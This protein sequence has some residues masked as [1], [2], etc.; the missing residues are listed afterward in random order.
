MQGQGFIQSAIITFCLVILFSAAD[1][2]FS[3]SIVADHNAVG[4]FDDIPSTVIQDITSQYNI[5]YAHTSHGSQIMTG[6]SI[7]YTENGLYDSP[8]FY[9]WGDDLGALGDT[10]W[11][12]HVRYYL[13]GHPDCNM[14][15]LSWCGGCSDNTEE[16]INAYLNKMEELEAAYPTVI[17]IYMT[18]HLDGTGVDGTLYANNNHIRDYCT[19][20]DKIL[21]DFADIESYDP[22]G[23]YYPDETDVCYWCADWCAVHTC[24]DCASCAH[25]HC[26]NC[27]LKGKGWW[28]MMARISGWNS[29]SDTI[30]HPENINPAPNTVNAPNNISGLDLSFTMLMNQITI[31][32]SNIMVHGSFG[33]LIDELIQFDYPSSHLTVTGGNNFRPNEII[34]AILTDDVLSETGIPL[35][36]NYVWEFMT[37]AD[38]GT[39]SFV[40]D[41]IQNAWEP[42]DICAGDFDGDG[43]IDIAATGFYLS[44]DLTFL[45]NNGDGTFTPGVT[46][47]VSDGPEMV[48]A[49]DFDNDHDLD[50][51]TTNTGSGNIAIIMN[52]GDATFAAPLYYTSCEN[53]YSI[54][55]GDF[56]GDGYPDLVNG[57][58]YYESNDFAVLLNNGD[59]SFGTPTVYTT[60][61]YPKDIAVS[62]LDNDFDL[63]LAV[64]HNYDG[65]V[66]VYFNDGNGAFTIWTTLNPGSL[67]ECVISLDL[68]ADGYNDIV[69]GTGS[70]AVVFLN[71]GT[72]GFSEPVNYA[73]DCG[74]STIAAGDFDGDGDIDLASGSNCVGDENHISVLLNIGDGTFE[75]RTD[76]GNCGLMTRL[77]PAD[78]DLDGDIDLANA[79]HSTNFN[80]YMNHKCG[81]ADG[82]GGVNILDVTY[83][84]NFL[85]REGSTPDPLNSGDVDNSGGINILDATYIIN[86][87]YRSGADPV[88]P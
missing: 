75:E 61:Q 12:P 7:L 38:Y 27:Y 3:A 53:P 71:N 54:H 48:T 22:D 81:D 14:V 46:V 32:S 36:Q 60:S 69:T 17:F 88:C 73:V 29:F 28:W 43:D 31:N 1:R 87:L 64:A 65:S 68:N 10:T 18:G 56:N 5:Y 34:T 35:E 47:S 83:L 52:N 49:G 42:S 77:C 9:E 62:D 74:S 19:A 8:Y 11:A 6:I 79:D 39:G 63:D 84:V 58:F 41:S 44:N 20:H 70:N 80:I 76:Y 2:A 33:G 26:F 78:Y 45:M 50:L 13:D 51:A 55:A 40:R 82:S 57:S 15:M 72:G 67:T 86:Y 59:G 37:G 66:A 25:S 24:P 85:Y 4:A 23:N 30:P 21:F 16:G